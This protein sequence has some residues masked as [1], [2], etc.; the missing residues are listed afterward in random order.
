M[1]LVSFSLVLTLF[2][3]SW[4][5]GWNK[6]GQIGD[7]NTENALKPI[8]VMIRDS[9]L[10]SPKSASSK[11]LPTKS[12]IPSSPSKSAYTVVGVVAA[13]LGWRSSVVLTTDY[14]VFGWGVVNPISNQAADADRKYWEA[15][16]QGKVS[17]DNEPFSVF[18]S[19]TK[20]PF[21][22]NQA[23]LLGAH[24]F[25][26]TGTSGSSLSM[27]GLDM[28]AFHSY[29]SAEEKLCDSSLTMSTPIKSK[30][31]TNQS[32][33]NSQSASKRQLKE[34]FVPLAT[35]NKILRSAG[36]TQSMQDRE[37][38]FTS[39]V[40]KNMKV[41]KDI[42]FVISSSEVKQRF[43]EQLQKSKLA[44]LKSGDESKFRNPSFASENAVESETQIKQTK[45]EREA[46]IRSSIVKV[47]YQPIA[48]KV[49]TKPLSEDIDLIS[50]FSPL[51]SKNIRSQRQVHVPKS[52]AQ[53]QQP[54][55]LKLQDDLQPSSPIK[56]SITPHSRQD[57]TFLQT[58]LQQRSPSPVNEP[59]QLGENLKQVPKHFSS[60]DEEFFSP[61]KHKGEGF[62]E[63]KTMKKEERNGSPARRN[64][65]VSISSTS[66]VMLGES[67][68]F[69]QQMQE[70][71]L[72]RKNASP[73]RREST[74]PDIDRIS[75]VTETQ[76]TKSLDRLKR[77]LDMMKRW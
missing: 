11:G 40:R 19:P 61:I 7:G 33:S 35:Q 4:T 10:P 13:S 26:L 46:T 34:D 41:T 27:V 31:M 63:S 21:S 38:A 56:H 48:S 68:S 75:V 29:L 43:K 60:L 47:D 71:G 59:I 25:N 67:M 49:D 66:A 18:L 12:S 32:F 20:L 9:S 50:L 14:Q 6:Y 36:S 69:R 72:L 15:T 52:N 16:G 54:F 24:C 17:A 44:T 77:E 74:K 39:V 58:F 53:S 2:F 70:L 30:Q 65:K 55:D 37:K 28:E 8:R 51:Q 3:C 62:S 57:R 22:S 42:S 23:N 73:Q 76:P 45:S 64:S 5:W 1:V